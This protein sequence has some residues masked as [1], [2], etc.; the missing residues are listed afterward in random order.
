MPTGPLRNP[1]GSR[2]AGLCHRARP[3]P[4][5]DP[6]SDPPSRAR[7]RESSFRDGAGEPAADA[8]HGVP[9]PCVPHAG[10]TAGVPG[11]GWC[12]RPRLAVRPCPCTAADP[13]GAGSG[14]GQA[15]SPKFSF[16]ARPRSATPESSRTATPPPDRYNVGSSIGPQRCG[17]PPRP[18]A[19]VGSCPPLTQAP[20]SPAVPR[21]GARRP[22]SASAWRGTARWRSGRGRLAPEPT[23]CLPRST[24]RGG[25]S[26]RTT[27]SDTV[28]PTPS[29]ESA[30]AGCPAAA[31]RHASH[32]SAAAGQRRVAAELGKQ[33]SHVPGPRPGCVVPRS[34]LRRRKARC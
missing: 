34:A 22:R 8:A 2:L 15:S 30:R 32:A 1:A 9:A 6:V 17:S 10:H 4:A 20:G 23:T 29:A 14:G 12:C 5:P 19:A 16:G 25:R 3:T 18:A 26:P 11:Q 28:R 24:R 7:P 31:V 13:A 33:Q 21:F 27:R